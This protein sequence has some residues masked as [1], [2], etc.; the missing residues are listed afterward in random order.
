MVDLEIKTTWDNQSITDHE[1]VRLKLTRASPS[2]VRLDIDAPFYNDPAPQA[3]VGSL[4]HL[5]DYEVVE[6]FLLGNDN[7]YL[8]VE[9]GPHGHY[10]VLLLDGFRNVI[11]HS[12]PLEP[13]RLGRTGDCE[14]SRRWT[15][16]AVIP[17]EYFPQNVTKLNAYAIHG[18][19]AA[20]KYLALSPVPTGKFEQPEFHRLD[21]FKPT[22]LSGVLAPGTD[23]NDWS[24]T[25]KTALAATK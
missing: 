20:R 4:M 3:A 19:D 17:D 8:E 9:F 21:Y 18:V 25:W 15:A 23:T 1:K 22:D 16:S 14:H 12:L 24:D 6:L 7:R 10:I 11:K 5:W 2:S 13:V